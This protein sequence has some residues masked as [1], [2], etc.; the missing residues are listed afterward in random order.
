MT[1]EWT[2]KIKCA[3]C[4]ITLRE[5]ID[6]SNKEVSHG[7]CKPCWMKWMTN[8]GIDVKEEDYDGTK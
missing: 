8:G 2:G 1:S 7:I 3:W 6:L 4:K 5:A